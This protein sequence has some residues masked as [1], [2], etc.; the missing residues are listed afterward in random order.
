MT[1]ETKETVLAVLN[2]EIGAFQRSL[3][4]APREPL[5][6]GYHRHDPREGWLERLL[7]ARGEIEKAK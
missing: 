7:K 2:L 3:S 5:H 6:G 1:P 4:E